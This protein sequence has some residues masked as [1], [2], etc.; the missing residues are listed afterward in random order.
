MKF[1]IKARSSVASPQE[2]KLAYRQLGM[3][4]VA[5]I[6]NQLEMTGLK[7]IEAEFLSAP[8]KYLELAVL[9]FLGCVTFYFIPTGSP[10]SMRQKNMLLDDGSTETQ[11]RSGSEYSNSPPLSPSGIIVD[12][13]PMRAKN[14]P[15]RPTQHSGSI[16]NSN[17]DQ[18]DSDGQNNFEY[19]ETDASVSGSE[20]Y[21]LHR[22]ALQ[23][24]LT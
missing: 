12:C 4:P 16:K 13:D 7:E 2:I 22:E 15:R 23:G 5:S 10:G 21:R 3:L 20:R 19:S 14:M 24:R 17:A 11:D 9:I 18:S 1:A 6:T 8:P